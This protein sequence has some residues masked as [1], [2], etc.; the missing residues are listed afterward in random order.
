MTMNFVFFFCDRL[1]A[2]KSGLNLS[3]ILKKAINITLK[4]WVA[5]DIM[6]ALVIMH[7]QDIE[8]TAGLLF[9]NTTEEEGGEVY[10]F[11]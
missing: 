10:L 2:E 1:E 5:Y 3:V 4:N 8:E 6:H 11:C 7:D 9:R